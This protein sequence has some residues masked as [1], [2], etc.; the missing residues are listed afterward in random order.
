M[1]CTIEGCEK[2]ARGRGYCQMHY[3]RFRR[4]GDPLANPRNK[5]EG[6]CVVPDCSSPQY[7]REHCHGHY[8]RLIED[9]PMAGAVR[10]RNR[11]EDGKK[12]CPGCDTLKEAEDFPKVKDRRGSWCRA[13]HKYSQ[14]RMKYGLERAEYDEMVSDGCQVCGSDGDLVIDHHHDSGYVR[15]ALCGQCNV[16]IGMAQ[17]SPERLEAM[18]E[19]LRTHTAL[20]G[21]PSV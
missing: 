6:L 14:K 2:V 16:A 21:S 13:C 19:Y 7:A 11:W 1:S 17:E 4:H 18:A 9:R 3:M 10:Q 15:G 12:V 20:M 8:K 5:V